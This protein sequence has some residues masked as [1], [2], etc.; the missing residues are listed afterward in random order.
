MAKCEHCNAEA[1]EYVDHGGAPLP[2]SCRHCISAYGGDVTDGH[3]AAERAALKVGFEEGKRRGG[4]EVKR[5]RGQRAVLRREVRRLNEKVAAM[6]ATIYWRLGAGKQLSHEV[7]RRLLD[8]PAMWALRQ[9]LGL[10]ACEVSNADVIRA[11]SK[12]IGETP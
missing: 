5:L 12:R 6:S 2:T 8:G 3:A 9:A 7:D 4:I 11:A 1:G 10:T